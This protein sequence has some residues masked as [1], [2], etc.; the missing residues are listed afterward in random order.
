MLDGDPR[1]AARRSLR[2]LHLLVGRRSAR[3]FA[4]ALA[5]RA[6]AGVKVHVLL[7]W[8]GSQKMDE[9][10][11][12]EMKSAGVEVQ[13]YHPLHWYAPRP[14]STTA[15]TAS[16]WSSTAGSA[17]PAASA[18]PTSGRG[19][20]QDPDHWRDTHFQRRRARSSRRCR[21]V[22]MDNWIKTTGEVLHGDDYFPPLE[23]VGE[24]RGADVQQLA[25]AAAA[26]ACS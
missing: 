11:V 18:S 21:R 10:L 25:R 19:N 2:D 7:D 22:F 1:R 16:S 23:P 24:R 12:D 9:A 14:R 20:A 26:R 8:V 3:Q 13:Q 5:E 17:S 4:D 6:R 15:R